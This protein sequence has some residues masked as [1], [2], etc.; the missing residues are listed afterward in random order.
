MNK[1]NICAL[2]T[3]AGI[4]AIAI[5]RVSGPKAI[6]ICNIFFKSVKITR[7]SKERLNEFDE[8]FISN[9][10]IKVL[11]VKQ[12]ENIKFSIFSSTQKIIDYFSKN[13][14]LEFS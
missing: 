9:S 14:N 7:I 3:A 13:K 10:I 1:D 6:N 5:I 11:P 2:S 12:I 4:G 8:M